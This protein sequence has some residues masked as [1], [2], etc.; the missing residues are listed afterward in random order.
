MSSRNIHVICAVAS[1]LMILSLAGS[2]FAVKPACKKMLSELTNLRLEYHDYAHG[3]HDTWS[4]VRFDRI[5]TI[6][7]EIV[8]L[9]RRLR[10]RDC[11]FPTRIKDLNAALKKR[12]AGQ[13]P[14]RY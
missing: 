7:D 11:R 13:A 6:L 2:A 3:N 10:E 5:C 9:K 1:A 4:E 14:G 8:A 12:E